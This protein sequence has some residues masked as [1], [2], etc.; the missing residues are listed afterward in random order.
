[1][2]ALIV[3]IFLGITFR[4]EQGIAH[5]FALQKEKERLIA[6]QHNLLQENLLLSLEIKRIKA[7]EGIEKL[8][9]SNLGLIHENEVVFVMN[10]NEPLF[11]GM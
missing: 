4:G 2:T 7:G 9:K 11:S 10:S 5:M 3:V 8:A 1:M 6:A